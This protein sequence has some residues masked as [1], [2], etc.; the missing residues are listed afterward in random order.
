MVRK[1]LRGG[2]V[3]ATVCAVSLMG[4][5]AACAPHQAASTGADANDGDAA[6]AAAVAVEWS[7]E[8]DCGVCHT[9][10]AESATNPACFASSHA[11][12]A[13]N[14]CHKASDDLEKRHEGATAG[15]KMP[16]KLK[17]TEVGEDTCLA[18][19]G[20]YEE[21]ATKTVDYQGLVDEKGTVVNPHALP[22]SEDHATL[23]CA[24]CHKMHEA[25]ADMAASSSQAC[26]TC[27]HE[28][29]FECGTCHNH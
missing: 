12:S 22:E 28:N 8:A 2:M 20:S 17:K 29:V 7:P 6:D 9:A 26:L 1:N 3:I 19:H 13:C 24:D 18:C 27:H 11:A 5:L 16:S 4:L 25:D 15:D 23:D 10:E 21:L 14:D